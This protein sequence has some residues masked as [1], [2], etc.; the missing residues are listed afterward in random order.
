MAREDL[1]ID[2]SAVE[3][4]RGRSAEEESESLKV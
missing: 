4:D 1:E 3:E 2:P